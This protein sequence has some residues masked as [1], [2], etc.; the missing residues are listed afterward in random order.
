M[1][2]LVVGVGPKEAAVG[3]TTGNDD[4]ARTAGVSH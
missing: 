2:S 1:R 3:V 4:A